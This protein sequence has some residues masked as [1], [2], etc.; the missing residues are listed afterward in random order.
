MRRVLGLLALLL[1]ALPAWAA[2]PYYCDLGNATFADSAGTDHVGAEYTG[3]AG[4]QAAIRGTGNATAL[5][6]G[7][8]LYVTGTGDLS[9]LVQ[10]DCNGY[11]TTATPW[12][13]GDAVESLDGG[14]AQWSG[15][16]VE[17]GVGAVADTILVW[18]TAG[19]DATYITV[20]YGINN[21][22]KSESLD[23]IT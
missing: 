7:E 17:A 21:T 16:V 5:A 6:A 8:I 22:T 2:G 19:K 14:A 4:M 12:D 10:I 11:D 15:V 18:M 1:F 9:R 23:P 3:P 20:A 13:E